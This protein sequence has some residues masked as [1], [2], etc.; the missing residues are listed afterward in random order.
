MSYFLPHEL[1]ESKVWEF[2]TLKQDSLSVHEYRLKFTKL[3]LYA[4][5][6]VVDIRIWLSLFVV[7]LFLLSSKE[8]KVTMLMGNMNIERLMVYVQQV[9][10]EKL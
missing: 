5:E 6:S 8:G 7:G 10:E 2:L 4:L 3:F 9:E 1:R